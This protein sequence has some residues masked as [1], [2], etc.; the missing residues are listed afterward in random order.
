MEEKLEE[1][2]GRLE[3]VAGR[4]EDMDTARKDMNTTLKE[5]RSD[6]S[7]VVELTMRSSLVGLYGPEWTKPLL[8]RSLYHL[9]SYFGTDFEGLS[10]LSDEMSHYQPEYV[11]WLRNNGGASLLHRVEYPVANC[12]G[13]GFPLL[14][15]LAADK[16]GLTEELELDCKGNWRISGKVLVIDIAEIKSSSNAYKRGLEHVTKA[17]RVLFYAGCI[18]FPSIEKGILSGH[19]FHQKGKKVEH[20]SHSVGQIFH[21]TSYDL[22]LYVRRSW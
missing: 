20:T 19:I 2:N 3:A 17:L 7:S 21:G 11:A 18:L 1:M 16:S 12:A 10:D 15:W 14:C 22:S 13:I 9:L 6:M 5:F 4:L 8:L